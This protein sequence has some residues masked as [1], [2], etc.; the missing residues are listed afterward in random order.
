LLVHLLRR[1]CAIWVIHRAGVRPGGV[2]RRPAAVAT[3][4]TVMETRTISKLVTFR[5]PFVL[6]GL[7][8]P[9][10]PGTYTVYMEEEMVD[11]LSFVGWRHT[12]S[13]IVLRR[14]G[15]VEHF[16]VDPQELR[17]ALVRDGDQGTDPPA[18]P[19]VAMGR[20]RRVRD[21]ARRA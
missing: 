12:S 6:S 4:G 7:D 1:V 5:K 11:T 13:A 20:N 9:E 17:E 2:K 16:P 10:P 21:Q 15:A 8:D 18:A 3:K 19:S 14:A